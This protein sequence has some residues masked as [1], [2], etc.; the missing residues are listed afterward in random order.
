MESASESTHS[1]F[2]PSSRPLLAAY[3]GAPTGSAFVHGTTVGLMLVVLT[4]EFSVPSLRP[5]WATL[6]LEWHQPAKAL[7][8]LDESLRLDDG[9]DTRS[10]R[11]NTESLIE[12][13][14]AK[15]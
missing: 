10:L 11:A 6:Y 14:K 3:R 2:P 4:Y 9:A 1:P 12:P 15:Q 5:E 7:A 8:K 13:L